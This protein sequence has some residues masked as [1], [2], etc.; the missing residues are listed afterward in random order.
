MEIIRKSGELSK[1]EIYNMTRSPEIQK[2]SDCVG[3]IVDVEKFVLYSDTNADG[4][5][6]EILSVMGK[7]GLVYATN[8]QTAKKE[9]LYIDDLMEGEPYAVKIVNGTSKNG[10]TYI[11]L[12]LA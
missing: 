7:N 9:F 6:Q 2:M 11:T 10:R 1:R 8:S 4:H 12:T 3:E 5:D